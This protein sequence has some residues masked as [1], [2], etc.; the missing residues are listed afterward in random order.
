MGVAAALAA[1]CA[2][3]G[4]GDSPAR[5]IRY[6]EGRIQEHP[7]LDPAYVALGAAYLDL[8]RQTHDPAPLA[9][10]RKAADQALAIQPSLEAYKLHAAASD[11]AH[12]F[13]DAL[14]WA[15]KARA[16]APEDDGVTALMVEAYMGLGRD[17][18]ARKLL[19]GEDHPP[20]HFHGAAALGQWLLA[21]GRYD[22]AAAS[23]S[24]AA[25]FAARAA[26]PKLEA[27]AE[28]QAAGA[29]LDSGRPDEARPHLAR[30][31]ELAP[32]SPL[33]ALHTAEL[34]LAEG[35]KAEALA[36]YDRL[37]EHRDDPEIHR[38]AFLLSRELGR[39]KEAERHF[40][41]AET[42]DRRALDAGEI[43]SMESLARLYCEAGVHLDEARR[44]AEESF[45]YK[46][47]RTARQTLA[48]VGGSA[49]GS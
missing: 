37:L 33:V 28:A 15:R 1:G 9:A 41:A 12:R 29:L 27:W 48:C 38:R 14:A 32:D 49:G 2:T 31:A 5:R 24:Q 46:R 35:R 19:P 39:A 30:A 10:A 18:E 6:Y 34:D 8:A 45:R 17:E 25:G 36:V 16:A 23:F 42:I 13:E 7:R 3:A 26:V 44:L 47:D 21:Q 22:E 11:F 40:R 43:Y 4:G 20:R